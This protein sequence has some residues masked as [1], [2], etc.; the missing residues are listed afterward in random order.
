MLKSMKEEDSTWHFVLSSDGRLGRGGVARIAQ[1]D[2]DKR[3][4]A[5]A[6]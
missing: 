5:Q 3:V 1:P 4:V 2:E 6:A